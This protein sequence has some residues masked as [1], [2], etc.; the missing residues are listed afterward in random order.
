[1]DLEAYA[2]IDYLSVIL[3]SNNIYVPRLRGLRLM[4]DEGEII[5][6]DESKKGVEIEVIMDLIRSDWNDD[7]CFEYSERVDKK[8]KFYIYGYGKADYEYKIRW[9]RIH[10]WR[11]KKLKRL[12]KQKI[13]AHKEQ[14]RVWN[15]FAGR[16]DIL[17]THARIGGRNWDYYKSEVMSSPRFIRKVDDAFDSS[18]CDIYFYVG[19]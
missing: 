3:F 12:I 11:R 18:Y 15:C 8:L 19:S 7:W 13:R 14:Y 16:P 5:F 1:M 17:Y 9:D 2:D 10:G 6:T 4:M